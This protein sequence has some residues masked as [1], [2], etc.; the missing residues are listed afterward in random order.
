VGRS[1]GD[2]IF[3][4]MT[5][6]T[7]PH[8]VW[9]SICDSLVD[10]SSIWSGRSLVSPKLRT[11]ARHG[12]RR[13]CRGAVS[14][15]VVRFVGTAPVRAPRGTPAGSVGLPSPRT[16]SDRSVVLA[17]CLAAGRSGAARPAALCVRPSVEAT[18]STDV[19]VP[20]CAGCQSAAA[21]S[22]SAP[23]PQRCRVPRVPP[24]ARVLPSAAVL[25]SAPVPLSAWVLP[26]AAGAAECPGSAECRRVS[27][28]LPGAAVRRVL[29]CCRVPRCR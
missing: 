12:D 14:A 26:S 8:S 24:G 25:P 3:G 16:P 28:V 11:P 20:P 21:V 7:S 13:P 6:A 1:A 15:V 27:G 10:C 18:G 29:Q 2:P 5:L 17:A 19:R 23:A 4:P 22:P 9:W